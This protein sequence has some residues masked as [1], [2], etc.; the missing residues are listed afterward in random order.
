LNFETMQARI[1]YDD[2]A[3]EGSEI[4]LIA[5]MENGSFCHC[6]LPV[7]KASHAVKHKTVEEIWY[8][9]DGE[10][11]VGA[12]RVAMKRLFR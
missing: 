3:P 2:L 11:G 9:L 4:R 6:T 1:N 7:G 8:F 12:S 5:R 10:G